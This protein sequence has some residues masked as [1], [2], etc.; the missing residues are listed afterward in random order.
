MFER[1]DRKVMTV[2]R[3]LDLCAMPQACSDW[4][5]DNGFDGLIAAVV[6]LN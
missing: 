2:L 3:A 6:Q 5:D 4:T 1:A